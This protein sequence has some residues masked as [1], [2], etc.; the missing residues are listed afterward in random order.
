MIWLKKTLQKTGHQQFIA[1]GLNMEALYHGALCLWSNT[2]ILFATGL[3]YV[4]PS[5]SKTDGL[6]YQICEQLYK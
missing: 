5:S 4:P 3:I 6:K 2:H 1:G